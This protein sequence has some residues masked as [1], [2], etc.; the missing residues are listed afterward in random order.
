MVK[1]SP[2]RFEAKV[3]AAPAVEV[4]PWV[5]VFM[6]DPG[7]RQ[8]AVQVWESAGFAVEIASTV[9][10]VLECLAV[11]TPLLIVTDDRLYR[12]APR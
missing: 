11:M 8:S 3:V 7:E 10:D 12:P 9:E 1:A 6:K 4:T 2:G 5:L